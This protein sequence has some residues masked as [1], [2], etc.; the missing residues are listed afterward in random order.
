VKQPAMVNDCGRFLDSPTA[1]CPVSAW[2]LLQ[3][4]SHRG[5][6]RKFRELQRR[7]V[8]PQADS[9]KMTVCRHQFGGSPDIFVEGERAVSVHIF[10]SVTTISRVTREAD[11]EHGRL[12]SRLALAKLARA[13][14][15]ARL[16]KTAVATEASE[17]TFGQ[18]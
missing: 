3:V 17:L 6:T 18:T 9:T 14:P 16:P 8:L 12:G 7:N 2:N 4:S 1:G 5:A 15:P 10:N 11:C 13:R